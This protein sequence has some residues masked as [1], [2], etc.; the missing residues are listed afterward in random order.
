M[1]SQDVVKRNTVGCLVD[2]ATYRQLVKDV[3]A[4]MDAGGT[5]NTA[6]TLFAS[7]NPIGLR[8]SNTNLTTSFWD[9]GFVNITNLTNT[10]SV[11]VLIDAAIHFPTLYQF[12]ADAAVRGYGD[13][14][15]LV[16]GGL[17]ES[18][19]NVRYNWEDNRG[20]TGNPTT[21]N[22]MTA[23]GS[24]SNYTE[25]VLQPNDVIT[26]QQKIRAV[27]AGDGAGTERIYLYGGQSR[28]I[29][30]PETVVAP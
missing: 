14:Q 25:I 28:I 9:S 26:V 17:V 1:A 2:E 12:H 23:T 22:E 20:H 11:P 21:E 29:G 6:K 4:L 3:C 30:H 8:A 16:N 10:N 18:R 7:N 15:I 19:N 13:Y 27:V 5:Q 24:N